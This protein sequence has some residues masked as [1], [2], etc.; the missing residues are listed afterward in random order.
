MELWRWDGHDEL[1][2]DSSA[3]HHSTECDS[4]TNIS[5]SEAHTIPGLCQ[6]EVRVA[7]EGHS[8]H[9]APRA[10]VVR[11]LE[12]I[13]A[14]TRYRQPF[15][16]DRIGQ[17]T[18]IPDTQRPRRMTAV[19]YHLKRFRICWVCFTEETL[20]VGCAAPRKY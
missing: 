12:L 18:E 1:H 16:M 7:A 11:Q 19:H 5:Y 4:N 9:V 6:Q 17:A 14:R 20:V 3:A 15:L 10:L 2:V 13:V 8:R